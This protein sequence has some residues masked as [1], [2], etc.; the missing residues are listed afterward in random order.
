MDESSLAR[1]LPKVC[2]Q[3]LSYYEN[4]ENTPVAARG[5]YEDLMNAINKPF[6]EEGVSPEE[7]I[8]DLI[9]DM[10]DGLHTSTGGRFYGWVVGGNLPAAVAADWLTSVWDQNS[11]LHTVSPASAIVEDVAGKWLKDILHLPVDASFAIVSGCQMA[12]VTAIAAAR[13][14][15]LSRRGIDLEVEGLYDVPRIRIICN[16]QVHGSVDRAVRLLGLGSK[17]ILKV[18]SDKHCRV[19]RESLESV[20]IDNP[21]HLLNLVILQ[22]GDINT[23]S[24]DD[25]QELIPLAHQYDAWVHIDG[26]FGLWARA[27]PK[28]FNYTKDIEL[29]DSWATDGH[30]WLNVPYDC[31]FVFTRHPSAHSA[32]VS[33][34]ASYLSHDQNARDQIDWNPEL[35]R[36]ARG[37]A[38]YAALR[39]LGR[40]GVTNLINR[41]CEHTKKMIDALRDIPYVEIC[42]E[43][44]INQALV[45]FHSQITGDDDDRFTEKVIE[46]I[47]ASGVAFFSPSTWDGR[48]VMR[49][50]ASNWRSND[51][52]V[53]KVANVIRSIVSSHTTL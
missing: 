45:C 13:H 17:S 5:K 7:V 25:F 35:S 24:F 38:V 18:R 29:A 46:K 21:H 37:N 22:A 26:A 11:A 36:R 3:S 44:I 30:K 1:L 40:N 34:R 27:S 15:L 6:P 19:K 12:H 16:D 33:H 28:Y 42:S 10:R 48:R 14:E 39:S 49:V 43:P 51:K 8:D 41:C 32:A 2:Q 23:G 9:E 31:G 47:S 4:L 20:L 52:D 50:S 53:E